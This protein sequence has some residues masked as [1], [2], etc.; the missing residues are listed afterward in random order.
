MEQL[1]SPEDVEFQDADKPFA[2][3]LDE[4]AGGTPSSQICVEL[5][6]KWKA[7]FNEELRTMVVCLREAVHVFFLDPDQV[8]SC[9]ITE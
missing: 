9:L 2:A 3:A 6:Y 8:R 4:A 1:N 7:V 5:S